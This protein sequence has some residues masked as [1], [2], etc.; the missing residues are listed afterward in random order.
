MSSLNAY[1]Q[2]SDVEPL[3]IHHEFYMMK[4]QQISN[5]L[6]SKLNENSSNTYSI[7]KTYSLMKNY[8]RS[9][10]QKR[11]Q[12]QNKLKYIEDEIS[13]AQSYSLYDNLVRE[14]LENFIQQRNE[15][16]RHEEFIIKLQT[17]LNET[18]IQFPSNLAQDDSYQL[19]KELKQQG[20]HNN[21]L[22]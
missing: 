3:N 19:M 4:I 17:I 13:D 14:E 12:N 18:L 5:D 11:I 10:D 20:S 22:I 2:Q 8:Q 6:L 16:I 1:I 9:L 7:S 21:Y 15:L